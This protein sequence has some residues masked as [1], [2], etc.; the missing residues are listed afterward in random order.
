MMQIQSNGD[1]KTCWCMDPIGNIRTDAD[2]ADLGEPSALVGIGML[3]GA[4]DVGG[5]ESLCGADR[6]FLD[7]LDPSPSSRY[8]AIDTRFA[9]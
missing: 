6:S 7:E 4:A 9:A 3:P 2:P 8:D 1:V 5:R